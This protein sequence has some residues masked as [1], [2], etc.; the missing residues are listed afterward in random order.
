M[1]CLFN[2]AFLS[3]FNEVDH[4]W[5]IIFV[6]VDGP[7]QEFI[8]VDFSCLYWVLTFSYLHHKENEI[9]EK[10]VRAFNLIVP[11]NLEDLIIE[12]ILSNKVVFSSGHLK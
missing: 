9:L 3:L 11:D 8:D 1:N 7:S 4:S 6:L 2:Y 10:L 5:V 12:L